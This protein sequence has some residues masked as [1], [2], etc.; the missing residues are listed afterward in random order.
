MFRILFQV[1]YVSYLFVVLILHIDFNIFMFRIYFSY[2]F[3][4]VYVSY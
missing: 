3:L 4:F 1:C 2:C